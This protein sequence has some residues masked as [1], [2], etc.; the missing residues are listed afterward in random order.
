MSTKHTPGPWH[1]K[2]GLTQMCDPD[3]TTVARCSPHGNEGAFWWIFSPAETHGDA[4]ADA[5]L[6]SAAPEL[7]EALVAA[8]GALNKIRVCCMHTAWDATGP[9]VI[10][11]RAAIAKATQE[12]PDEHR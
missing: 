10:G 12:T 6:I 1:A 5:R 7:L 2:A 9:A 11:A 4:E 8:E 3:A